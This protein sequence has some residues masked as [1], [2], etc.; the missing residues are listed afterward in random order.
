MTGSPALT[1]YGYWRSGTSYRTRIAL[2][3]KG[4]AYEQRPVNL[5]EN[6]QSRD[7]YRSLNPQGLVPALMVDDSVL[8]QS[9]A[10]L[11]WLEERFPDPPLLPKAPD[12]RAVVRAMAMMVACDI[13]PLNNIR[14]LKA[15]RSDFGADDGARNAWIAHWI[16]QGFAALDTLIARHGGTYA[17][18]DDLSM[19][20][21]HIVPQVYSAERFHVPLDAYPAL[22][23]AATNARAHPAV[24][25]A[26]PERQ[27]DASPS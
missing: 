21:C 17:F 14:V 1:L 10:I 4:L 16:T 5:L 3:L 6:A 20:D 11:E 23:R 7:D 18:G 2:N 26:S 8:V 13:H 24:A 9:S 19:A 12:L 27:P 22:M 15:L 25:A